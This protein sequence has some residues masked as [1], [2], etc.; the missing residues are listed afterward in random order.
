MQVKCKVYFAL[1]L[2]SNCAQLHSKSIAL[3]YAQECNLSV[4]ATEYNL[5]AMLALFVLKLHSFALWAQLG[6][7]FYN[8]YLY[9]L[10]SIA[11]TLR[12]I[13]QN[14]YYLS[15]VERNMHKI[16]LNCAHLRLITRIYWNVTKSHS[17]ALRLRAKLSA[18]RAQMSA[19]EHK[20]SANY[21]KIVLK[22]HSV[23]LILKLHSWVQ[24]SAVER[25]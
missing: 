15:A 1:K 24:L 11:L 21:D 6:A 22:L 19:I 17:I 23:A 10:R 12:A 25:N 4:D 16:A 2:R 8:K 3:N 9:L 18:I 7:I 5:S 13:F 14:H 20:F